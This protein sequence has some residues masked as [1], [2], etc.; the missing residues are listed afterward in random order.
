MKTR[1][2][3][4]NRLFFHQVLLFPLIILAANGSIFP[5]MQQMQKVDIDAEKH[6]NHYILLID[7]SG[8]I[9]SNEAK[10]Q[11]YREILTVELLNHL[12]RDGFGQSIPSFNPEEDL[13]S[14]FR[15]GIVSQE[16]DNPYRYLA[17][18]DLL[19]DFVK[20][21]LIRQ[22]GISQT[23]LENLIWPGDFYKLTILAWAKP[24]ALAALSRSNFDGVS[25]RVF[26]IMV[27]DGLLNDGTL[28]DEIKM[29]ESWSNQDKLGDVKKMIDLINA[30][31][32]FSDGKGQTSWAWNK[33]INVNGEP[34]FLEAY[35]VVS[36][37]Q[38]KWITQL[39]N[40]DP[41]L[42][43]KL[44]FHWTKESGNQP[45]GY[46][47]VNVNDKFLKSLENPKTTA[48]LIF[49]HDDNEKHL[50]SGFGSIIKFP[51][52]FSHP[53]DCKPMECQVQLDIPFSMPFRLEDKLLGKRNMIYHYYGK[54][55][56][57][58]PFHCSVNYVI[59]WILFVLGVLILLAVSLWFYYFRFYRFPIQIRFPGLSF[60]ISVKRN[61]NI[62]GGTPVH[63]NAG[64]P[65]FS[66]HLPNQWIQFI[67]LRKAKIN[68]N[69]EDDEHNKK[70]E[71]G[72]EIYWAVKEGKLDAI[73]LPVKHKKITVWW[74][75]IPKEPM[76]IIIE[77][78]QGKHRSEIQLYFPK[79][80][81]EVGGGEK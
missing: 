37:H 77:Y 60:P 30:N 47:K 78:S 21:R 48:A 80:I 11:K 51:I 69:H 54:V 12:F 8:S 4:L 41:N 33:R 27:H 76:D 6:P 38:D 36:I 32:I 79:G 49:V 57:P 43:T 34:I 18:Y 72:G 26:L 73:E 39:K 29:A 61:T 50:Q 46:L 52:V 10:A 25:N 16:Y 3:I 58:I 35:E 64:M 74:K 53:L 55:E 45:E 71:T 15:F 62:S 81:S 24:L 9:V 20:P 44:S 42:F 67:L 23:N 59:N 22:K 28:G 31:Y 70:K 19:T 2:S 56:T 66:I 68:L 14:L 5:Q 13:L 40:L 7:A 1:K 17:D 65:A 75:T 63:P